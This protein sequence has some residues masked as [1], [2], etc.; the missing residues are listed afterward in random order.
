MSEAEELKDHCGIFGIFANPEA[1]NLT[2]LGL[3]ALQHRGQEAAGIASSD[4]RDMRVHRAMGLVADAFDAVSLGS[5][6]GDRAIGH[7]RYATCG[8]S[9]LDNAQPLIFSSQRGALALAHNGNLV[10]ADAIR[11]EL[12]EQG[13]IFHTTSD[14][15]IIGHLIA[16]Q[17][18]E[19]PGIS[20]AD[21][22]GAALRQV[23]GAYSLLFLSND[24]LI[25]ARDPFG[26]RPLVIG[27]LRDSY[28]MASETCALDLIG[29]EYIGEVEPGQMVI[30]DR[31]GLT[32]R[33]F[34]EAPA[35]ARGG[36][37]VFEHIY[38][39]RPDSLL[40]GQSVH[41]VRKRLGR[42]LARERPAEADVVIPVP[43]SGV[44]AAIGFAEAQGLPFDL[45]LVRSHY[46]GRTF[47]EPQQSIR[48]LGVKLKLSAVQS[49]LKGKRVVVVDDSL[50]RGTTS[51]KI[52]GMIRAAGAKEV[53][54]RIS[55]PPTLFPCFY[56]IDTPTREELIASSHSTEEIGSYVTSDSLG[57]L[58][59][60]GVYRAVGQD[61]HGYC[62]A[63]FSGNYLVPLA[64]NAEA[65]L[66]RSQGL[67]VIGG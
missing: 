59:M 62:D 30:L 52:V 3:H 46:V 22:I 38:F 18:A 64:P 27:K 20:L 23:T 65:S 8:P 55:S 61:R 58:S 16:K 54:L 67:R 21:A 42:E 1:A 14:T 44:P 66:R 56:G 40:F 47:I 13:S 4:G 11:E 9:A 41:E 53:H 28:T 35:A 63:C 24:Q 33:Q 51:R 17:R 10:N 29:A 36:R 60:E 2:Y 25:A 49:V 43:D 7:V 31:A 50:V 15:E 37:C 39:A 48:H 45:G 6:V 32:R 5:L 26:F 34:A 12:E 19:H 57:Y